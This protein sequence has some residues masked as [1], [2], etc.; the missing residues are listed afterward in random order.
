VLY[1]FILPVVGSCLRRGLGSFAR[2]PKEGIRMRRT[3]LLLTSTLLA[4]LLC[5]G[6]VLMESQRRA[7]AAF[8]GKNGKVAFWNNLSGINTIRAD[9]SHETQLTYDRLGPSQGDGIPDW[10][11]DGTKIVFNSRRDGNFEIYKMRADGSHQTRLTH[12]AAGEFPPVW[13]PDGTKI[14]YMRS[15]GSGG[16]QI[17]TMRADGSHQ[18]PLT[19]DLAYEGWYP[20]W[21]PDGTKLAFS[22]RPASGSED[23]FDIYT[24]NADGSHLTPLTHNTQSSDLWPDW[25]PMAPRSRSESTKSPELKFRAAL[26]A[27]N[28]ILSLE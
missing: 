28:V 6:A 22:R 8:P 11:S 16:H 23:D 1:P 2:S 17:Y 21:S 24:I 9:G 13:S 7:E 5:S 10:S 12:T 14:A 27:G 4:V 18:V 25:S 26:R 20:E 3:V 15:N 19:N